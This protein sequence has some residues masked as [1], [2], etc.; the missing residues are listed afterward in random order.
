MVI[1]KKIVL[2]GYYGFENLG[3]E[4]I[5][6]Y[7]INFLRDNDIEPIVLSANPL[8]TTHTY[9]VKS[10][11]RADF[12]MVN[13]TIQSSDGLI[14]GGGSLLQ[15]KTSKKSLIYYLLIMVIARMKLKPIYFYGQGVGPIK[16]AGLRF[17]TKKILNKVN[18]L[19]VRDEESKVFLE[20]IGIDNP[21]ELIHDPVLFY[22]KVTDLKDSSF[23]TAN[24]RHY[25][26]QKPVYIS[27]RPTENNSNVVKAFE[28][29]IENLEREHIPVISFPFHPSQDTIIT[30]EIFSKYSNT[31]FIEEPLSI[32]QAA[33][34][35]NQS[36]L[37]VGLRLHSLII[38]ASQGT[39]FIG[40]SY[41]P[42]IDSFLNKFQYLAAGDI[43]TV[44]GESLI[45]QTNHLLG[46]SKASEVILENMNKMLKQNQLFNQ[47]I[48]K[49]IKG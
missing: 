14:S 25:L 15:D 38:A 11:N 28:T 26:E 2:S 48:I 27:L 44:T 35:L 21:I 13:K 20:S 8:L 45:T 5:L 16:A 19:S 3:D 23:L 41:D 10:I 40:V 17:F 6:S 33:Y 30:K 31:M 1:K 34:I 32:N 47:E 42:K 24:V 22:Q 29:Y 46:D 49:L 36:R 43:H 37:V 12:K 9:N 7:L 18:V 39:P 4:A